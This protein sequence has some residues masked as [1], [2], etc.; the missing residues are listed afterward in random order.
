MI[1]VPKCVYFYPCLDSRRLIRLD[2]VEESY[3]ET[4]VSGSPVDQD[5]PGSHWKR[6]TTR[7]RKARRSRK[8]VAK[9]GA[10]SRFG[11]GIALERS[12][13]S[14]CIMCTGDAFHRQ[15]R[16]F[17]SKPHFAVKLEKKDHKPLVNVRRLFGQSDLW[18]GY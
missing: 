5:D 16:F 7:L 6:Y 9:F 2:S 12:C 4:S 10:G 8:I 11:V 17:D 14:E 3:G 18:F 1:I 15:C 13:N